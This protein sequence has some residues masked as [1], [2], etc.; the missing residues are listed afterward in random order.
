MCDFKTNIL[1]T[2]SFMLQLPNMRKPQEFIVYPIQESDNPIITI[3]SDT[4]IG[5]I[6]LSSGRGLMS[7]SHA[8]GAYFV[9][10]QMDKKTP[11]QLNDIQLSELKV[12]I[13]STG[14]KE[15]GSRGIVSD[16]SGALNIMEMGGKVQFKS[17]RLNK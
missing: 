4:R 16:N 14:G 6:D 2:A 5:K 10:L 7:E 12:K 8:S 15:V 9:H 13:K 17:H 11:F 1:G 3:Q